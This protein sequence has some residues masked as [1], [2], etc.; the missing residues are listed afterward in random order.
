MKP[1]VSHAILAVS[2]FSASLLSL[3]T[4]GAETRLGVRESSKTVC[5]GRGRCT[6]KQV[7]EFLSIKNGHLRGSAYLG[8][9]AENA[10]KGGESRFQFSNSFSAHVLET[11]SS[12]ENVYGSNAALND[13]VQNGRV[14]GVVNST[15]RVHDGRRA[16][17][18]SKTIEIHI[19][20]GTDLLRFMIP[21]VDGKLALD[22][23]DLRKSTA[24]PNFELI[25]PSAR[26][27][28]MFASKTLVS[29]GR[30]GGGHEVDTN[31]LLFIE[32]QSLGGLF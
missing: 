17:V 31:H 29:D 27:L 30:R 10:F 16:Y 21:E 9:D 2:L 19:L 15:A 22:Q 4:A 12:T 14:L 13:A 3:S 8:Q 23:I 6:E 24:A 11:S 1:S 5:E 7:V 18:E 26:I 28:G 25:E 20:K 32:G